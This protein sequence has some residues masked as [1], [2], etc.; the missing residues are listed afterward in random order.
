MQ[1][2]RDIEY[3]ELQDEVRGEVQKYTRDMLEDTIQ[4]YTGVHVLSDHIRT[5]D[6]H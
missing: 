1:K 2:K 5:V 6:E 4:G 3:C